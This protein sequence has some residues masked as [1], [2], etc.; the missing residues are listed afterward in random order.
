MFI[1]LARLLQAESTNLESIT[2]A[3]DCYHNALGVLTTVKEQF[4]PLGTL[5]YAPDSMLVGIVYCA[6]VLLKVSNARFRSSS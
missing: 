3:A 4:G 6:T 1:C 2:F 5:K